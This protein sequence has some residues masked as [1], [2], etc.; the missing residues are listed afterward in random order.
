M[1]HCAS[2]CPGLEEVLAAIRTKKLTGEITYQRLIGPKYL[3]EKLSSRKTH[4]LHT[5]VAASEWPTKSSRLSM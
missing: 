3:N 5:H 4:S 1:R 2:L